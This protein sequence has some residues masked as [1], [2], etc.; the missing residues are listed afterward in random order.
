MNLAMYHDEL[1]GKRV[2]EYRDAVARAEPV[3]LAVT[4]HFACNPASLVLKDDYKACRYGLRGGQFFL[5]SMVHY[6]G[7]KKGYVGRLPISRDFPS[8][9]QIT[10]FMKNRNTPMSQLSTIIGDPACARETVQR[11]VD[12][13]VDEL[14]MVMQVGTQPH[15]LIMESIKTFGEEVIPHFDSGSSTDSVT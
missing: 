6:F 14:I 2:Q 1:F 12:V 8:E 4:N 7:A 13:G 9:E 15:E 10:K 3:G 5:A 11:F